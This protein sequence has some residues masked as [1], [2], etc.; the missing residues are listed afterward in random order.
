MITTW[1]VRGDNPFEY[2]GTK[3]GLLNFID[4]FFTNKKALHYMGGLSF[5]D[6]GENNE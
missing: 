3:H 1:K 2:S 4:A 6:K 5:R